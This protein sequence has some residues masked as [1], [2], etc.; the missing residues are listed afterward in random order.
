MVHSQIWCAAVNKVDVQAEDVRREVGEDQQVALPQARVPL[1]HSAAASLL[2]LFQGLQVPRRQVGHGPEIRL[3]GPGG[4]MQ[5]QHAA[6]QVH[7][8]VA[9]EPPVRIR[10][11]RAEAIRAPA[12]DA[13]EDAIG[14]GAF[15]GKAAVPEEHCALPRG[16]LD[17]IL[18]AQPLHQRVLQAQCA[19]AAALS[20]RRQPAAAAAASRRL[21]CEA[22]G[23]PAA[24]PEERR[25]RGGRAGQERPMAANTCP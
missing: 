19:A 25:Q 10:V 12:A 22:R 3:H 18:S 4:V 20:Q 13:A 5:A 14:A 16:Q 8:R 6:P 9:D 23:G 1:H 7:L 24:A 2:Q 15:P 17:A 21:P 11:Q